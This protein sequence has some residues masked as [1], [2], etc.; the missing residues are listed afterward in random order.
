MSTDASYEGR[1]HC[2]TLGF[3]YRTARIPREWSLRACQCSF[4]RAHAAVSTSDP[5]GT[6]AFRLPDVGAVRL[7]RFGQ[8]AADFLVCTNC[9]VYIGARIETP[10]GGFGIINVRAL[11]ALPGEL[12][13][14]ESM[15]YDGESAQQRQA[16]REDRWTPLA[17]E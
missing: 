17:R 2:G 3:R 16:R 8:K 4:C 9:G 5:A 12:P 1:C 7:Y 14:P 15:T 10:R 6:L 13:P 11:T